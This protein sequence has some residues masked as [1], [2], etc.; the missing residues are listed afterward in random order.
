[1][2]DNLRDENN[3][4]I[5]SKEIPKMELV[6]LIYLT[7]VTFCIVTVAE[8]EVTYSISQDEDQRREFGEFCSFVSKES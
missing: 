8:K 3:W 5:S 7:S 4:C 2:C 6:I 1:M